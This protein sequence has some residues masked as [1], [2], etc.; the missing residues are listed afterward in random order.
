MQVIYLRTLPF[1]QDRKSVCQEES[2]NT[3]HLL[4]DFLAKE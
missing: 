3:F 1:D 2:S 4:S